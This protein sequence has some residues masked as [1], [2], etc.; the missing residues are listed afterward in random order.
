MCCR[1]HTCDGYD[2]WVVALLQVR[3]QLL[4]QFQRP[5]KVSLQRRPRLLIEWRRIGCLKGDGGI[6]DEDV[7]LGIFGEDRGHEGGN[8]G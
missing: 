7:N 5:E 6:V 4:C 1:S 2:D 8:A 3:N